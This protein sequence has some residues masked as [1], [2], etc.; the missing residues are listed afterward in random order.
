MS[1]PDHY[2]YVK[3]DMERFSRCQDAEIIVTTEKDAVKIDPEAAPENLYYLTV[4]AEIEREE[5]MML[6]IQNKLN[7]HIKR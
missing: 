1:Y 7:T 5:E 6:L 2:F 3:K 4:E